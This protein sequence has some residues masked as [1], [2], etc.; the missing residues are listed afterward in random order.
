MKFYFLVVSPQ[1][2]SGFFHRWFMR[3]KVF[4]NFH[5]ILSE[6]L[7]YSVPLLPCILHH[8]DF[9]CT[10]Q[11]SHITV[12]HFPYILSLFSLSIFYQNL[13]PGAGRCI[14][15][16]CLSAFK[17]EEDNQIWLEFIPGTDFVH[18]KSEWPVGK[19]IYWK[20]MTL[21]ASSKPNRDKGSVSSVRGQAILNGWSR[22]RTSH[23]DTCFP[24]EI[25]KNTV[26]TLAICVIYSKQF[27]LS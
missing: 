9:L 10:R 27:A 20:V 14:S 13:V 24:L 4:N 2:L 18:F 3:A 16:L 17:S 7:T 26:A 22:L 1:S 8:A 12:L 5:I 6:S 25:R 23:L 11:F 21:T 19:R 15:F